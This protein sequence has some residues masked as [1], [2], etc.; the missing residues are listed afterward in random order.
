MRF[1]PILAFNLKTKNPASLQ[2]GNLL[3]RMF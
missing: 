3:I 1:F 2:L